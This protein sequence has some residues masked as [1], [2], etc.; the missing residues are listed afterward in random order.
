MIRVNTVCHS[1][2]YFKKQLHKKQTYAKEV[3][4]KGSKILGHLLYNGIGSSFVS[5]DGKMK[6][7]N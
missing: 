3:W 4:N 5:E 2:K 6:Y 1:T 7:Q